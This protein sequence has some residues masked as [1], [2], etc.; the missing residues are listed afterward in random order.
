MTWKRIAILAAVCTAALSAQTY[1]GTFTL[2]VAAQWGA[3]H[4]QPG[5]YTVTTSVV[6]S[7]PVISLT[8]NG[9]SASILSGPVMATDI[10]SKGGQLELAEM[11]GNY[12]VT[13]LVSS[14]IGREFSFPLPKGFKQG[15]N[16]VAM[17]KTALPV[18]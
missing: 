9:V 8:G 10:S 14:A 13:K 3:V 2:P 4:L 5:Q 17:Q 7:M 6:G 18:R 15:F 16:A 12:A 11:N 1:R